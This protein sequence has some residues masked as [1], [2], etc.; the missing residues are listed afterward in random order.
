MLCRAGCGSVGSP[1]PANVAGSVMSWPTPGAPRFQQRPVLL[2]PPR[3]C[4]WVGEV[5]KGAPPRP[6][7]RAHGTTVRQGAEEV[8]LVAALVHDIPRYFY[9]PGYQD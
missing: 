9:Q 2:P 8:L 1:Q 4:A 3:P 7:R 6:H 5:G